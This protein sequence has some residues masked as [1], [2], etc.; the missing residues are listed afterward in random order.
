V[1]LKICA[2]LV[3][4]VLKEWDIDISQK[5]SKKLTQNMVNKAD[6]VIVLSK[7]NDL[8]DYL[9]DSNKVIYWNIDEPKSP[10]YNFLVPIRNLIDR[11][12]KDL[13]P[14]LD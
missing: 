6:K 11:H 7:R 5:T 4:K 10:G 2:P 3:V 13:I 9:I 8:P 12:V 14:T 1:I